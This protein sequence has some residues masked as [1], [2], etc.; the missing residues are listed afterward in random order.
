MPV[1]IDGK[2]YYKRGD[3]LPKGWATG[4]NLSPAHRARVT[5]IERVVK[6]QSTSTPNKYEDKL[7]CAEFVEGNAVDVFLHAVQG[8]WERGLSLDRI[9]NT[10]HYEPGNLRW[11]NQHTQINNRGVFKNNNSGITGIEFR[12][13]HTNKPWRAALTIGSSYGKIQL[14]SVS[15]ATKEEA[16]LA[17]QEAYTKY[18]KAREDGLS[19]REILVLF[20]KDPKGLRKRADK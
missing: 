20:G 8:D 13:K 12:K 10:R 17:R 6:G 11:A 19:S 16:T 2:K 1:Y 18:L 15:F 4:M 7:V 3:E 5:M 9:D 14:I